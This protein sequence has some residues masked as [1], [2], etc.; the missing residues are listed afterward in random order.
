MTAGLRRW[1]NGAAVPT[2]LAL[3]LALSG[4]VGA[5]SADGVFTPIGSDSNTSADG[6]DRG[7]VAAPGVTETAVK[8]GFIQ[9]DLGEVSQS[10]GLKRPDQGD[11]AAQFQAMVDWANTNG[12][13]AGRQIEPLVKV[14]Q[15]STDSPEAEEALCNGLT[16]DDKVFGVIMTGQLQAN[17]RPCYAKASTLMLEGNVV[18]MDVE[19]ATELSPFYWAPTLPDYDDY[20]RGLLTS[21]EANGFFEGA[22]GVGI[23]ANQDAVVSR[24]KDQLVIPKLA[25]LGFDDPKVYEIDPTS[26]GNINKGLETAVTGLQTNGVDRVLFLGDNRLGPFFLSIAQIFNY[27]ARLAIGT[28][29][30]PQFLI[31]NSSDEGGLTPTESLPGSLGAGVLPSSEIDGISAKWEA[32]A[33]LLPFPATPAEQ[34]CVE[35]YSAAGITFAGRAEARDAMQMCDNIRFLKAAADAGGTDLSARTVETGAWTLG[36]TFQTASAPKTEFSEGRYFGTAGYRLI[37]FD[38]ACK[39]YTYPSVDEIVD[40]DSGGGSG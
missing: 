27:S 22:A 34:E 9:V 37:Q 36:D 5:A 15:A 33:A 10:L 32:N 11:P 30:A 13:L 14:Y 23:V 40:F 31:D 12:G 24:A 28:Y 18:P 1:R 25:E 26:V 20:V 7:P 16:Q 4:C 17:A 3:C 35:I 39:C 38:E 8:L 6:G 21:L 2:A 29:D 19:G